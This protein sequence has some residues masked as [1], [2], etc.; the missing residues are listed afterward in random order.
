MG[1]STNKCNQS[2][3]DEDRQEVRRQGEET[4][5]KDQKKNRQSEASNRGRRLG[6]KSHS[7]LKSIWGVKWGSCKVSK[8]IAKRIIHPSLI[9]D[10]R[11]D[12]IL[13]INHTN[14]I[15]IIVRLFQKR[16]S[17]LYVF[18]NN[19]QIHNT[20]SCQCKT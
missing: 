8:I 6:E 2:T 20:K 5:S 17:Q 7:I 11:K 19:W 1:D 10:R 3:G 12:W 13:P 16:K 4:S 14:D 18:K 15:I 9:K